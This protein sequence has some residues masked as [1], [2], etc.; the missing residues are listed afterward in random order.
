MW[1][2]IDIKVAFDSV[3]RSALWLILKGAGVPDFLLNLKGDLHSSMGMS[4]LIS[5]WLSPCFC[6][7]STVWKGCILAL[8]PFSQAINW[9]LERATPLI[10]IKV[11]DVFNNQDY[12]DEAAFLVE[13]SEN[14]NLT[15]QGLQDTTNAMGLNV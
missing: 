7:T 14:F 4:V 15:L 10:T 1:H 6:T 5:S 2:I 3:D 13:K 12:T 11:G 8:A 9:I